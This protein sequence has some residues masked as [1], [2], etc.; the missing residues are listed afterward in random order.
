M[1][2]GIVCPYD[3]ASPGGVQ[4]L[5]RELAE[6]LAA[7]GERTVL[8]G[9][10]KTSYGFGAGPEEGVIAV[11][12]PIYLRANNSVVPLTFSPASWA[13]V[14]GALS[15]VDVI[16]VHEPL[17]PLVGWIA[18]SVR[19]PLVATFHADPPGWVDAAYRWAPFIGRRLRSAVVT[20]V[21]EVAA[22]ALPA[23]WGD[24]TIV[25]NAID[26]AAY[27][28]PVGRVAKRVC[29]LGRDDPRKGLD[30]LLEAWPSIQGAHP[31]SELV[32][33]GADRTDGPKGVRFLGRVSG[34]EK[35]RLL[36]SSAVYVAPNTG[37]ESFG[38]VIAEGMAA[39][40]AVVAS[41]LPAF[42]AVL[43]DAG[44]LVPVG[45]PNLLADAVIDLLD[46]PDHATMLGVSAREEVRRFDWSEVVEGYQDVYRRAVAE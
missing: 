37:G 4:Q 30:I 35:R 23:K 3:L 18:V 42:K 28:V 45:Q 6:R 15:D 17:I 5:T 43:G 33:M 40:C 7:L 14:R 32:V 8:V 26:V 11:G 12:R 19:K 38:I 46:D 21:S 41:D 34:A 13:R 31:D 24:V 44:T 29:F 2:V 16:H 1:K 27:E 9:A 22:R 36:A 39:G 10:G 20:A 25:P